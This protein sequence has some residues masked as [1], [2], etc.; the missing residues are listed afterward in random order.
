[1]KKD[2]RENT[3]PENGVL[4][5]RI[6]ESLEIKK[7]PLVN[8]GS[9]GINFLSRDRLKEGSAVSLEFAL[10]EE[11]KTI[12]AQGLVI[13]CS[14]SQTADKHYDVGVKFSDI[15]KEDQARI[16]A[17]VREIIRKKSGLTLVT[18]DR[19]NGSEAFSI[20]KLAHELR[21]RIAVIHGAVDNVVDGVFG[22]IHEEQKKS[23]LLA[24][25]G[26]DR[27]TQMIE[28]MM[29]NYTTGRLGM[30]LNWERIALAPLIERVVDGMT[31]MAYKEGISVRSDLPSRLPAVVCDPAKIEQVLLNLL[32]N[33]LKFTSRG[34]RVR[35]SARERKDFVEIAVADNGV[36]IPAA[37][38]KTLFDEKRV[39]QDLASRGGRRTSGLGLVIV[40]EILD[41]HGMDIQVNSEI[42]KGSTFVFQ[43]PRAK[44]T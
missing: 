1:M 2:P 24:L 26:V 41:A 15:R 20:P 37:K 8:V 33:A 13:W 32:R 23:L 34:G 5:Y 39:E 28:D 22:E 10:G 9:G 29:S 42:G 14:A 38:L 18:P 27:M 21:A 7:T 35:V 11:K 3:A 6:P 40:K 4:S 43:L 17:Y 19:P 16:E 31:G 30:S 25:N 36:G 44:N 12:R